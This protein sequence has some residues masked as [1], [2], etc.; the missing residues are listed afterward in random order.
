MTYVSDA[1]VA[2]KWVLNEPD[3][4]K[5]LRLRDDFDAGLVELLAP[6]TFPAEVGHARA[7]AERRKAIVVGTGIGLLADVLRTLPRL[8]ASL[9]D[10]L[11]RAFA[12]ASL[13]RIGVYDCLYVALAE[14]EACELVTADDKLVRTLGP[15]CPFIRSLTS[16]P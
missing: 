10:L 6:D 11:P 7:K 4:V 13:H 2:V 1:S 3:S 12:I 8:H 9:P 14:R 16:L 5:A 15:H